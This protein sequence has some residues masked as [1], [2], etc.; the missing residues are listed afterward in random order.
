MKKIVFTQRVEIV[1]SYGERRD[2]IDQKIIKFLEACG[3]LP[4][5]VPN[6]IKNLDCY[7]KQLN[8]DGI[9][10][11]GG[12]S[13]VR[14]GGNAPERDRTDNEL[15]RIAL[16]HKLP[17]MGICRGMQS[18]LNYYGIPLQDVSGHAGKKHMVFMR[19]KEHAVIRTTVN[20]YH[21]QAADRKD[22]IS[23]L[24]LNAYSEEGLAESVVHETERL[25][26]IMWHPEREEPFS[27]SDMW[28]LQN[29]MDTT[30]EKEDRL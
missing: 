18:I 5:P 12:N 20:S 17:L 24:L 29:L 14:Y 4:I 28:L 19:N 21:N 23:P 9:L 26:G 13:L 11:T 7:I 30:D 22:I 16:E 8:P 6:V 2:C 27:A 1:E 15:I 25:L 10:L 3:L